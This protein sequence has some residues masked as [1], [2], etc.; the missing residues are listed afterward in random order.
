[1]GD[2]VLMDTRSMWTE[3]LTLRDTSARTGEPQVM[4]LAKE[5]VLFFEAILS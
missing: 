1:M 3:A 4:A 5:L 2:Q